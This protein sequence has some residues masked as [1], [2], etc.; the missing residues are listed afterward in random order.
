MF[1][2]AL[3]CGLQRNFH[4]QCFSISLTGELSLKGS[5][6]CALQKG[7]RDRRPGWRRSCCAPTPQK[8]QPK[9]GNVKVLLRKSHLGPSPAPRNLW[10]RTEQHLQSTNT[11]LVC[12]EGAGV[13][14]DIQRC[15]FRDAI[16]CAPHPSLSQCPFSLGCSGWPRTN[17]ERSWVS[18]LG[19]QVLASAGGLLKISRLLYSCFKGH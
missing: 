8:G 1:Y 3:K 14:E 18:V 16:G 15:P 9:Q 5:H 13:P 2:A 19:T 6:R 4:S 17:L 7:A 12:R 11:F 10:R